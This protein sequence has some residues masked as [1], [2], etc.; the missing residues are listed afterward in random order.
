M[1]KPWQ[2]AWWLLKINRS[3]SSN[4]RE[5]YSQYTPFTT[6]RRRLR[7]TQCWV[8]RGGIT[9]VCSSFC[10]QHYQSCWGFFQ[11]LSY[12]SKVLPHLQSDLSSLAHFMEWTL[13]SCVSYRKM[14]ARA[15]K[16]AVLKPHSLEF[17]LHHLGLQ[18][19]AIKGF[20]TRLISLFSHW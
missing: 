13:L 7:F 19:F 17:H 11:P 8:G 14:F 10:T 5:H 3:L 12:V 9:C 1:C 4:G 16:A 6:S 15:F 20:W 18:Y 2:G